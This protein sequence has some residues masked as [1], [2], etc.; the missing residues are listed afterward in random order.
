RSGDIVTKID[1]QPVKSMDDVISYLDES[2]Q[3]GDKVTL[4]INREGQN[5]EVP[6]TLEER[7]SSS[8][9]LLA[10]SSSSPPQQ[11]REEEE[12]DPNPPLF[13]FPEIPGFPELPKLFP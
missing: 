5:L 11:D 3:V 7:P 8:P 12:S 13:K 2:K 9:Q 6:I 1:S 10:A 4:T